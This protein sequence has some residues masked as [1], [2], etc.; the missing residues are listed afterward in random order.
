MVVLKL[1]AAILAALAF[2]GAAAAENVL[3]FTAIKATAIVA[4][5][6]ALIARRP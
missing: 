4:T 3:R 6:T 1:E 2:G 5:L